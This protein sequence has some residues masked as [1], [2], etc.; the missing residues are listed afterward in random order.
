MK[1]FQKNVPPPPHEYDDHHHYPHPYDGDHDPCVPYDDDQNRKS[2]GADCRII[3]HAAAGSP[4]W[5]STI[6]MYI[7]WAKYTTVL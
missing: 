2:V 5:Q 7:L 6:V 3:A 4:G 1:A